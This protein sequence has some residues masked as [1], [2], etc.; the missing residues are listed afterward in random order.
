MSHAAENNC[1]TNGGL[2][3]AKGARDPAESEVADHI[4]AGSPKTAADLDW[5]SPLWS[6]GKVL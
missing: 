4:E 2:R 6:F 1:Q 5:S 3:L